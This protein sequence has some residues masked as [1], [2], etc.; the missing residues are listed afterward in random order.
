MLNRSI[1][2]CSLPVI[3]NILSSEGLLHFPK[4]VATIKCLSDMRAT[5]WFLNN[6]TLTD[7]GLIQNSTPC[8]RWLHDRR[9]CSELHDFCRVMIRVSH[10]HRNYTT[11]NCR[12]NQTGGNYPQDCHENRPS[13]T[14]QSIIRVIGK[15]RACGDAGQSSG[16]IKWEECC[17]PLRGGELGPHLTK[18]RKCRLRRCVPPYIY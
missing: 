9:V 12:Y 10:R 15:M 8:A 13:C 11:G 16:S 4:I 2:S 17:A 14:A 6:S 7:N 18:C 3:R 5:L 1:L